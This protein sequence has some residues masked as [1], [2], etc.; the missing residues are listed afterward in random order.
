MAGVAPRAG[1]DP[2]ASNKPQQPKAGE[3]P[4]SSSSPKPGD[5]PFR[6]VADFVERG[7]GNQLHDVK[8]GIDA[9]AHVIPEPV[10][11]VH[12][13]AI[14]MVSKP[15]EG[16]MNVLGAPQRAIGEI[17]RQQELHGRQGTPQGNPF[18]AN[19]DPD[20]WNWGEIGNSI[21]H[22]S[23]AV[24][25]RTTESIR[26]LVHAPAKDAIRKWANGLPGLTQ[27]EKD[28]AGTLAA[29]GEDVLLQ[30]GSDP[31]TLADGLG[32][33]SRVAGTAIRGSKTLM[34]MHAAVPDAIKPAFEHLTNT[35][36]KFAQGE[37]ITQRAA[38]AIRNK[39]IRP[40]LDK[41]YTLDG[42]RMRLA[43]ENKWFGRA[44]TDFP[45]IEK[46]IQKDTDIRTEA[47]NKAAEKA[48]QNGKTASEIEA[49]RSAAA[50]GAQ[51]PARDVFL[52]LKHRSGSNEEQQI[53]ENK[54]NFKPTEPRPS[55]VGNKFDAAAI[56]QAER[57]KIIERGKIP[58]PTDVAAAVTKRKAQFQAARIR[59]MGSE[60]ASFTALTPDEKFKELLNLRDNYRSGGI[61][62]ESEA[63]GRRDPTILLSK[64][65]D[66]VKWKDIP[67]ESI[68]AGPF[69]DSRI[70][71]DSAF[72]KFVDFT[73]GLAKQAVSAVPWIH[74]LRNVGELAH[75]GGGLHMVPA[76]FAQVAKHPT[77]GASAQDLARLDRTGSLPTFF[78]EGNAMAKLPPFKQL[79]E[80]MQ[81]MDVGY[82]AAL[83]KTLDKVEG[84][85]AEGARI[86]VERE[87][88]K[89]GTP[90]NTPDFKRAVQTRT[91]Q[92]ELLKGRSVAERIGDPRNQDGIVRLF[93]AF[94][95]WYPAFR[96][97]IVPRNVAATLL[98]HPGRVLNSQRVPADF[99][100]N[101][102]QRDNTE[103]VMGGPQNDADE[104]AASAA[105]AAFSLP[106][107][108]ITSSASS[109]VLGP[110]LTGA[111]GD[112]GLRPDQT[113]LRLFGGEIPYSGTARDLYAAITGQEPD[114]P[115]ELRDKFLYHFLMFASGNYEKKNPPAKIE[116][117]TDRRLTKE[118]GQ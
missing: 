20:K 65:P 78:H 8:Y 102:L 108:Y 82:R 22:P 79:Q 104:M 19:L 116:Q 29:T 95:G 5:N 83:L 16:A 77:A 47:G 55:F 76:M 62:A 107:K 58:T 10:K 52:L 67:T 53:I 17:V 26:A 33:I 90:I 86:A 18:G 81:K 69:K 9:V 2:F 21:M 43:I 39:F 3:D 37:L 96:L 34:A 31:L 71:H 109:G 24:N 94:G 54:F 97:G 14:N 89:A 48:Q 27:S 113:A 51:G 32:L 93:Q 4:F 72:G 84:D 11:A 61:A 74:E 50:A 99:N 75:M 106:L 91:Y 30:A 115:A 49:A 42:K 118:Y 23:E 15:V 44:S 92:N 87:F 45:D 103:F 40:E 80:T 25:A 111:G 60:L 98:E 105:G 41:V 64:N 7:L 114:A 117:Q 85:S 88:K 101:R 38:R 12:K 28:W 59:S 112:A 68:K 46:I 73:S 1:E 70:D 36:G 6:A 63:L 13:A 66:L 100:A 35:A 56:A 57:A 110:L